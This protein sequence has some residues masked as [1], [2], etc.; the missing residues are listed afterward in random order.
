MTDVGSRRIAS[1]DLE[2]I[3]KDLQAWPERDW[4]AVIDIC[5]EREQLAAPLPPFPEVAAG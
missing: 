1:A 3:A 4:I 5:P 2:A